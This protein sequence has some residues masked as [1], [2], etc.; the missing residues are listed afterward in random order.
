ML[1]SVFP[2]FIYKIVYIFFNLYIFILM[3]EHCLKVQLCLCQ[4]MRSRYHL[5]H[6]HQHYGFQ[7]MDK[8][9]R[10]ASTF[11]RAPLWCQPRIHRCLLQPEQ[12]CLSY[13]CVDILCL[14]ALLHSYI[15]SNLICSLCLIL[16]FNLPTLILFS[17]SHLPPSFT[18]PP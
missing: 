16:L 1:R 12:Q 5:P 7:K 15:S 14:L 11:C 10:A 4:N 8:R 18:S 3:K 13:S 17:A 2:K 9:L 6:S